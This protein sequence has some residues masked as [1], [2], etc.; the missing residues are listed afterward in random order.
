MISIPFDC[1]R[2][3]LGKIDNLGAFDEE[4]VT[5]GEDVTV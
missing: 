4:T 2:A 5:D 1:K 3:Y